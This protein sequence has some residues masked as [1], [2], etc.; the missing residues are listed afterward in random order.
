MYDEYVVGNIE[1][2]RCSNLVPKILTVEAV[3]L[4]NELAFFEL[5][6]AM[7]ATNFLLITDYWLAIGYCL[8]G[9]GYWI[10]AIGYWLLTIVY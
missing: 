3:R 6:G 4:L 9:I 1:L 10:L 8:L 5:L 2:L 7:A